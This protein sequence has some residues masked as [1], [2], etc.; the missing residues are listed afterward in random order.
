[1]ITLSEEKLRELCAGWQEALRL[2]DWEVELRQVRVA[3]LGTNTGFGECRSN[4]RKRQAV[5]RVL[6][7][8]DFL[9]VKPYWAPTEDTTFEQE[10]V[11][12]HELLHLL[13]SPFDQTIGRETVGEIVLE[14]AI[15]SLDTPLVELARRVRATAVA[16]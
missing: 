5:I 9:E 11:V 3:E 12:V 2:K 7:P 14:Q 13:F 6:H 1:M 16:A 4:P 8:D 15:N 10:R